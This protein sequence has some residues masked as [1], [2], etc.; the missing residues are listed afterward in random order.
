[1]AKQREIFIRYFFEKIQPLNYAV[2]KFIYPSIS[3]VP[4]TSDLD[5]LIRK[6]DLKNCLEIIRSGSSISRIDIQRKSFI[7]FVSIY[8]S[9]FSYLEIDFIHRFDRKGLVYMN[10]EDVLKYCSTTAE[11]IKVCSLY[12]NFEYI[13]LFYLSNHSNV[14]EKYAQ[15][16]SS[17]S[18]EKRNAIFAHMQERFNLVIHTLDDFYGYR[19]S[20]WKKMKAKIL[21]R[22]ENGFIQRV[23]HAFNYVGDVWSDVTCSAGT[24]ITFSGVD[25]AGKS[26]ILEHTKNLL[27]N[28][29]R[30]K[31]V[32]LRHRPSLFPILSAFRHGKSK[33]EKIASSNLP[34]QGKNRNRINSL[35]RFMY[36]Y[37]DYLV[38]QLYVRLR[39]TLRGY[40]VLYDRYYFD[41][42]IDARRS[43]ISLNSSLIKNGYRFL[44]KPRVN[45]FLYEDSEI[46]LNRKKELDAKD[47]SSLTSQY[48]ELFS[49]LA[50]R[51]RKHT[52]L[53]I[54]NSDLKNTLDKV[55]EHFL[56]TITG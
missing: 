53:T 54:R 38:G 35:F 4:E 29:Y 55:E 8:F 15:H 27:Q 47:I 16:F 19:E 20:L 10:A 51:Y 18:A 52:Y 41:F 30:R 24:T 23:V 31:I 17:F 2:M 3:Q 22:D 11:N 44:F 33:A 43:N 28:K 37:T 26:T 14:E 40:T 21:K 34:R 56:K 45:V 36:Y 48:M 50:S 6:D 39:Y 1:M 46:I 13:V 32:V 25:G 42:I 5:V 12:H 7:T 49:E 9:D